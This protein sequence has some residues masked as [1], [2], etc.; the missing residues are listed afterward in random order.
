MNTILREKFSPFSP[1]E[2]RLQTQSIGRVSLMRVHQEKQLN[3]VADEVAALT[4]VVRPI[5]TGV[6][7][8]LKTDIVMQAGGRENISLAI[9]SRLY[10]AGDGDCGICFEYAVHE[11]MNRNDPHVVERVNDAIKLCRIQGTEPKSILFGLEKTGALQLIDT[12]DAILTDNSRI[13]AGTVGQPPKLRRHLNTI[14]GAFRNARTRPALPFS[15]RGMW[16]ADLVIG[17]SDAD[18]WVGTSVKINPAQLEAAPGL[19]IGIVPSKQGKSDKVVMDEAK[20][21][22][23]CPLHHDQDFMQIFYEGWRIVQAFIQADAKVPKEVVLP[24]PIDREVAKILAER[25]DYAAIDVIEAL[26]VFSQP[27]LLVT[28]DKQVGFQ[29]LQGQTATNMLVAPISKSR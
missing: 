3:P 27:E 10:K 28:D 25:R 14:V 17:F 1:H 13:L 16:K 5:L 29:T 26:A 15:I 19:R 21:M 24:R 8:A 6:L 9:L 12:A 23:I 7:Y 2:T 4:A 11:A 22:V 20:N 18:R